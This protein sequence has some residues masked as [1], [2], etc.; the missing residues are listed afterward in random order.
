MFFVSASFFV[1]IS[2]TRHLGNLSK[3]VEINGYEESVRKNLKLHTL[4]ENMV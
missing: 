4:E 2:R 3:N 1:S